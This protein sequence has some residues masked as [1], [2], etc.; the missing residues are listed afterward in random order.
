MSDDLLDISSSLERFLTR[1][2]P[3][4]E[5]IDC[6]QVTAGASQQT[7]K[8]TVKTSNNEQVQYAQADNRTRSIE[9][10]VN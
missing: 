6:S 5:L 7:F 10:Q 4:C 1:I 3:G 8:I 9:V 2:E